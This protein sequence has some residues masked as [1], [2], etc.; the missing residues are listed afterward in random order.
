MCG[1]IPPFPPTWLRGMDRE[2]FLGFIL[3]PREMCKRL[4]QQGLEVL[5]YKIG[6]SVKL[7]VV[8]SKAMLFVRVE[9]VESKPR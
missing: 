3:T 5:R 6:G 7:I 1:D 8:Y 2:K 4:S 9:I